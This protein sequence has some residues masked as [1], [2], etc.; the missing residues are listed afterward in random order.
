[1]T[2]KARIS[3]KRLRRF[4]FLG[5]GAF[6]FI[7]ALGI[8]RPYWEK[9]GEE[10]EE[11]PD[12]PAEAVEF[13]NLQLQDE[14]GFIAPDGLIQAKAHMDRM[15]AAGGP[16]LSAGIDPSSWTWLG[17]GNIGGR[18]RA[19][20][21]HPA[22]TATW[23]A[24]SVS[25]GI[26]KTTDSGG[27]WTPVSDFMANLAV[28]TMVMQP[29]TPDTI[30][31]GTGEGFYN[32]DG[33]RGAGIFKSTN[34][35]TSW[36]QLSS[37]ANSNF[38][39]V[40]RLAMSANG[41]T[42]LAATR[43]G[44][45]RST[46]GG[47]SFPAAA[48]SGVGLGITDINFHPADSNL[49]VASGFDGNAWYSTN[50]GANWTAATGLPAGSFRRVEIAYAPSNPSIVYA[51]VDVNGGSIYSSADGGIS[52][53]L[54]FDTSP[55][56]LSAQGWYDNV[57]WVD[58]TNS[59][60][61]VVG[62]VDL[63]KSTTGGTSF[64][65]ISRWQNA[66]NSA[67][68]DHH[69]IVELPGFNGAS[70]TSVV[71][72]NDGGVYFTTNVYTVGTDVGQNNFGWIEKNN[73]LG[74]TQYYGAAGNASSGTIVGGTQD[75]GTLRYTTGGGT[76]G[77]TTMFGGDGGF[78]AADPSD[79][80]YFYGEYVYLL[81]HRS[82]NGGVS[83]S[84]IWSGITDAG[85]STTAN[86]IAP[87]IL[88]PNDP[89][90]MLAGG[91]QLWRSSNVKAG[92]P[93]WSS[94]KISD[95]SKI[96]AIAVAQGNPDICW[97]GH[98]NGNVYQS[99]NC[100][101]PAPTWTRMDNNAIALPN[102]FVQRITIDTADP[103]RVYVSFGGFSADNLW[104][105]SN[106]GTSWASA[107]G[108]GMTALPAAPVRDID[109]H[110]SNPNWLYAA[111]EVGVLTSE[112]MGA[113]WQVPQNGPANVSVDELAWVGNTLIAAT[114]GRGIYKATPSV[115]NRRRGQV[116]SIGED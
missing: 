113:T 81:I 77:H 12:F 36:A 105:T 15:R 60:T 76:E 46:D 92:T 112:D 70:N 55:D 75:N 99:T 67:H 51:S 68:A 49:A 74:I 59:S 102:R 79:P 111:T 4:L 24:G 108:T 21:V 8:L 61:L 98:N 29:G 39:Y 1:M 26:W 100:T 25:G 89:T 37:T 6:L 116:T 16:D 110:P 2:V 7:F 50:G 18:V 72:G 48:V 97:V 86:F 90:R 42:L 47:T 82:I 57:V 84:Y 10:E 69:A 20:V 83:S 30:Y 96:S 85:S 41:S 45:Y 40:N 80:N 66:Q 106:A 5:A 93:S 78:C 3:R 104:R 63:W 71:F 38:L 65:Q 53:T 54:V 87:F 103:N 31:A 14:N 35:G 73:N 88:D 23:L 33:I 28:S 107:S 9:E 115:G 27:T 19:I 62:G 32:A 94:I 13:R 43:T 91:L 101:N 11:G 58:P 95:G 52:Y 64:S 44:I 22:E 109:I 56:Y 114:H 34:G 17:P